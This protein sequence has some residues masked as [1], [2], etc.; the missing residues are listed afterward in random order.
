MS[1]FSLVSCLEVA[2]LWLEKQQV[3]VAILNVNA[4]ILLVKAA[5]LVLVELLYWFRHR[6]PHSTEL[7]AGLSTTSACHDIYSNS[8][9]FYFHYL[10]RIICHHVELNV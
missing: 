8:V 5:I 10:P 7:L 1:N 9:C 6:C 3:K 4:A 2:V